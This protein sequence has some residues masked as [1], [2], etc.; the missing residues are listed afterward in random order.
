MSYDFSACSNNAI[1]RM[2]SL[3]RKLNSRKKNM[4]IA[5]A[6]VLQTLYRS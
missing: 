3:G 1:T 2:S 4:K 5:Q 6:G